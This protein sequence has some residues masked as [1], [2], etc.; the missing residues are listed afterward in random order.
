MDKK[1]PR[2]L[3]KLDIGA[4]IRTVENRRETS[5]NSGIPLFL[6]FSPDLLQKETVLGGQFTWGGSLQK[7]NG[8]A[9]RLAYSGWKSE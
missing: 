6:I 9:Q 4:K 1:T 2:A 5:V 7:G 8:G 3:L